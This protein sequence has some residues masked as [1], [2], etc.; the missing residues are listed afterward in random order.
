MAKSRLLNVVISRCQGNG[1]SVFA[2]GERASEHQ[3]EDVDV[4]VDAGHLKLCR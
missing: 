1:L 2:K 4:L 3:A